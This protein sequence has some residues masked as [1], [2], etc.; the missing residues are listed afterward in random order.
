MAHCMNILECFWN[1]WKMDN[2]RWSNDQTGSIPLTTKYLEDFMELAYIFCWPDFPEMT[3][4]FSFPY[5][6]CKFWRLCWL[7]EWNKNF[8]VY[9]FASILI[10]S[11]VLQEMKRSRRAKSTKWSSSFC[12]R[13]DTYVSTCHVFTYFTG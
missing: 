8:V 10:S 7:W 1:I 3:N 6:T 4:L 12:H 11:I 9:F 5:M 2:S 13:K